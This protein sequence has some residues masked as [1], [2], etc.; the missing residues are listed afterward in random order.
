M[1]SILKT[2]LLIAVIAAMAV[3]L[4]GSKKATEF[5]SGG[6]WLSDMRARI[7]EKIDD[8]ETATAVLAELDL[9]EAELEALDAIVVEYYQHLNQLDRSYDTRR[10]DFENDIMEFNVARMASRDRI[11]DIRF[12]MRNHT[13]PDQWK[14]IA[15][16]D[17]SLF[18]EY[19]RSYSL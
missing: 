17:K 13:T 12:R 14:I 2:A 10:A 16:I 18:E 4:G 11:I 8:A 7:T 19:Q 9:I 15:D 6:E 5:E 3:G 1:R